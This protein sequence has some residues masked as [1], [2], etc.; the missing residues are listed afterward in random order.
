MI[1]RIRRRRGRPDVQRRAVLDPAL[2]VALKPQASL[3]QQQ[4]ALN[5]LSLYQNQGDG[6]HQLVNALVVSLQCDS[7][8]FIPRALMLTTLRLSVRGKP[9][10]TLYDGTG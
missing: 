8:F 7:L 2:G 3:D 4:A 6:V 5:L 1:Y 10:C 9:H